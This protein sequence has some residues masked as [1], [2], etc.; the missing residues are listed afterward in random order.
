MI[1]WVKQDRV[2][3]PHTALASHLQVNNPAANNHLFTFKYGNGFCPMTKVIFL[4]RINKI[5]SSNRWQKLTG[6]SVHVGST[7]E[8]LLRGIPFDI[9]K[10]K[11]R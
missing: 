8:Y 10:A 9:V 3:D 1:F 4:T 2:V 11:G 6:H 7:L 5:M